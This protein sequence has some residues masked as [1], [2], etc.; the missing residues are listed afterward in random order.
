MIGKTG[1]TN[2]RQNRSHYFLWLRTLLGLC[3]LGVI[4][5]WVTNK[6]ILLERLNAKILI[7]STLISMLT[8]ML[9]AATLCSITH[10]YERQ[11]NYRY[12]LY[13]SALGTFGNTVGGLPLGTTLKY[14]ILYK[15][16]GLKIGQIVF[17]LTGYTVVISLVLLGYATVSALSLD[18]RL[19]IK[20]IPGL[21]LII[22]IITMIVLGGWAQKS[23]AISSLVNPF[24]RWP[25]FVTV[26]VLSF[27]LASLFILNAS[28]VGHILFP[29]HP[30]IHVIFLS[31][32]GIFI[33]LVSLLQS[34]AG[35]QEVTMGLSAFLSGID[36]IDGVQIALVMRF[37]SMIG[38]G[39]IL[40]LSA[41]IPG[42]PRPS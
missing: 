3:I 15:R 36:P 4:V 37:T 2:E 14:V 20:A 25:S 24:L 33:S 38:S 19:D 35:I 29:E 28:T 40:G 21:L 18:F 27:S 12:A 31:A 41:L 23:K 32:I 26:T 30:L 10:T 7:L 13:I 6:G 11:L 22:G 1:K 9:H 5:V 39:M 8:S 16:V 17:G 34:I 42:K